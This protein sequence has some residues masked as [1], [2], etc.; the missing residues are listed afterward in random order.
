V[1]STHYLAPEVR[2]AGAMFARGS[3]ENYNL[4]A[5]VDYCTENIPDATPGGQCAMPYK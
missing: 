1:L 4:D 5:L 3:Q 2:I